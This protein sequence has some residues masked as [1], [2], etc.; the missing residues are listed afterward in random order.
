MDGVIETYGRHRLLSFDR[1]PDTREPTVEIA[2]EA[3]LRAW[4]RLRGWI[5]E[6]R[7]DLR[8]LDRLAASAEEWR[9]SARDPSLLLRGSKLDRTEEWAASTSVAMAADD[10][11][12][13]R[14]ASANEIANG[15][16]RASGRLASALW[17]A[18]PPSGCGHWWRCSRSPPSSRA[19]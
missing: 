5:D 7:D 10:R 4:D 15:P 2:H 17:S 12:T 9:S 11:P 8:T 18:G 1:D 14:R 16:P 19:P 6:A 3:L 13:S